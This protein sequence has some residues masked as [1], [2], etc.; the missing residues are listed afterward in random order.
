[1]RVLVTGAA[2]FI[3][4]HAAKEFLRRGWDVAGIDNFND[5]YDVALKRNRAAN[6]AISMHESDI[7]DLDAMRSIFESESPDVVL[8]LAA[9]PGVRYSIAHPFIYQKTNVEG[10]LNVLECCRHAK[11]VPKL[12]FASSS[13]VYGGNTKMPFEE[14]DKVD[15]PVSLYAATKKADELMAHTYAHLYKMQTVGLRFFTVY[16]SWYRPDMALSLFADAMLHDRPIKAFNRGDM[17]RDFTYVDD[18]VDGVVRVVEARD[19]PLYDIFNIGNHRSER[20]LDVIETLAA[21]LGVKPK[22]EMLPMQ[23]GDVYAT[24]ASIDKL[25]KAVGYEPRTTIREGIPVFAK[26]FREYYGL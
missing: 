5:Y 8:H 20:L 18:I 9:Q 15:T 13:S 1:M 17:L 26:W 3:G 7:C 14:S 10:F 16:G 21:A 12:V 4:F 25:R 22:M 2:G 6:L 19:L 11:K 24:Y 23:A